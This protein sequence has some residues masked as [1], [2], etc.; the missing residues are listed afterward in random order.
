MPDTLAEV[1]FIGGEYWPTKN[2]KD[3]WK[4]RANDGREF[5]AW[6]KAVYE[7]VMQHLGQPLQASV[8]S[9]QSDSGT[10]WNTLNGVPSLG[11]AAPRKDAQ[12]QG[13]G[14]SVGAAVDVVPALNRI[15]VALENLLAMQVERFLADGRDLPPKVANNPVVP[16]PPSDEGPQ[17]PPPGYGGGADA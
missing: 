2:G 6:D 7:A 14:T 9:K 4:L 15:A 13:G 3:R 11:V 1:T 10:W 17:E 16:P 12:P 8:Y 5:G